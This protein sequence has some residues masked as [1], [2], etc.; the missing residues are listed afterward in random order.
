MQNSDLNPGFCDS[1]YK[2][3]TLIAD[4]ESISFMPQFYAACS[5][6][7]VYAYILWEINPIGKPQLQQK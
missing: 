3:L 2:T 5:V 7:I 6:G 1:N 4:V